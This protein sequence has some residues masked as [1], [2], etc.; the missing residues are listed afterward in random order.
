MA[1]K[2]PKCQFENPADTR[3]CDNCAA[4]LESAQEITFSKT[5]TIQQPTPSSGSLAHDGKRCQ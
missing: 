5:M 3:F 1:V 4:P 2:C